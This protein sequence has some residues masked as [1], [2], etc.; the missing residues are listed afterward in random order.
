MM[1]LSRQEEGHERSVI[2]VSLTEGCAAHF[3]KQQY[4]ISMSV[5]TVKIHP[6]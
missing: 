3:C 4:D 5:L 2:N 6:N 1:S